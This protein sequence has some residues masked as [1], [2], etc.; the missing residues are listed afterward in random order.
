MVKEAL[1]PSQVKGRL[2]GWEAIA[3][4]EIIMEFQLAEDCVGGEGRLWM[5][6]PQ[7][8]YPE[9]LHFLSMDPS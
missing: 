5:I 7:M 8:L 3:K 6:S 2:G 4:V 1:Q 9:S